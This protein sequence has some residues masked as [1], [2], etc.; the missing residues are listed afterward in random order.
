MS[1]LCD[2]CKPLVS[3]RRSQ[4][5]LPQHTDCREF[6]PHVYY[7]DNQHCKGENVCETSRGFEDDRVRQFDG[8]CVAVA[9]HAMCACDRGARS[10][11]KT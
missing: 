9:L 8:S 3:R 4:R 6:T 5:P 1:S 11:Q 2:L 10:Y 7:H